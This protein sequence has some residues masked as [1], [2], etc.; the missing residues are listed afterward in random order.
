MLLFL[1]VEWVIS[2][3]NPEQ[4]NNKRN[5]EYATVESCV[6][7]IL[8]NSVREAFK[9]METKAPPGAAGG[10]C[11]GGGRQVAKKRKEKRTA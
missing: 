5:A 1:L 8:L 9:L 10:E 11:V 6:L 4:I 3:G 2:Q 7:P